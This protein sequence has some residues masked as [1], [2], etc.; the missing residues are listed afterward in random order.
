MT[1]HPVSYYVKDLCRTT[2]TNVPPAMRIIIECLYMDPEDG[3]TIIRNKLYL[4]NGKYGWYYVSDAY[5]RSNDAAELG[6][7]EDVR[8]MSEKVWRES[9]MVANSITSVDMV[10]IMELT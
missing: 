3:N 7:M 8:H 1:S 4:N 10:A 6:S 5:T 2:D 9:N